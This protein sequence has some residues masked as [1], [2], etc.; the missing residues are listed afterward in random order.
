MRHS[1]LTSLAR[2]SPHGNT[3][4]ESDWRRRHRLLLLVLAVH[5][6][7]L[8]TFGAVLQRAP[9]AVVVAVSVPAVC[10][11]LGALL[12]R[13]RRVAAVLVTG[14]LVYSS[15]ALVGLTEGSIGAHFHFF[16]IIGFIALYQ[17][18]VPFLCSVLFAVISHAVGSPWR[19]T[20]AVDHAVGLDDPWLWSITHGVA[21]LPACVG[22]ALLGWVSEDA[23]RDKDVLA[24]ELAKSEIDRRRPTADLLVNLGRRNQSTLHRQL[25]IIHQLEAAEQDPEVLAELFTLDRLATR[26][27]RN[28]ESL[29][30]LAGEAPPRVWRE[31]APLREVVWAAIAETEDRDRVSALIDEGPTI[32]GYAVADVTHL[33]AELTENAVRY[34]PPDSLVRIRMRSDPQREVGR[35]LLIEDAGIG[36][37][38]EVLAAANTVLAEAPDVDLAV[39]H[40]LGFHVV[41]RLCARHG[42]RVSLTRTPG[43]GITAVVALPMKLFDPDPDPDPELATG[44]ASRFSVS[45][46]R[47][48]GARHSM[49]E[50]AATGSP[51]PPVELEKLEAV[52]IW[53]TR[54][55][56]EIVASEPHSSV[57]R[58]A[59][60][61]VTGS[62]EEP[63]GLRRRVP[64]SHLAP[65]L[66]PQLRVVDEPAPLPPAP[67]VAVADALWRYQAGRR[68]A[69]GQ[70]D[71]GRDRGGETG[72]W[73]QPTETTASGSDP[74]P[75]GG[76]ER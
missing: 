20:L 60:P 74:D 19:Q 50:A 68:A 45:A 43:S 46:E 71:R 67:A 55:A 24:R 12:R 56:P 35:L 72:T 40:R 66:R 47:V 64:Q 58:S 23:Q 29:L 36:M 34:S 48:S 15:A 1:V 59:A 63:A 27:Q 26:V 65:Q 42:I 32:A 62:T 57:R 52:D 6:P 14:G 7:G 70:D 54:L 28:A 4:D 17:D 44:S 76:R 11:L 69:L 21:V 18:W 75:D 73:F 53:R 10:L 25:E 38:P 5:V 8:A 61:S 33:L 39:A 3:L 13:R 2:L 22:A 30:V 16:V 37:P 49:F 41:A 51:E 9:L 31:P